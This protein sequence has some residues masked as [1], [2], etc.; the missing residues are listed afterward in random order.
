MTDRRASADEIVMM[1][2]K[3]CTGRG[4]LNSQYS[5]STIEYLKTRRKEAIKKLRE[6]VAQYG[7]AADKKKLEGLSK[8]L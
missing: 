6:L 7:T 5:L 1:G 2:I 8:N 4:L 3:F